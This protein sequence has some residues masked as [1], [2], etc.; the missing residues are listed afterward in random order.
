MSIILFCRMT[1]QSEAFGGEGE[2]SIP[3]EGVSLQNSVE[4]R[5]TEGSTT[6]PRYECNYSGCSRSYSTPSNLKT[7][8]RAHAGRL[9]HKCPH[10]DCDKA[11]LTSYQL[12]NHERS[13][14][15]ERPYKCNENGCDKRYTTQFRLMAHMRLHSGN[16]FKCNF[17]NCDKEFTTRSDLKKHK[18]IHTGEKPYECTMSGCGKKFT[19]SH[20]LKIHRGTHLQERQSY[21]CEDEGCSKAFKSKQHL[22]SHLS[23][24]HSQLSTVEVMEVEGG[25]SR[26]RN[27]LD[28]LGS[29]FSGP[30][31]N[32]LDGGDGTGSADLTTEPAD[33]ML[34]PSPFSSLLAGSDLV[35]LSLSQPLQHSQGGSVNLQPSHTVTVNTHKAGILEGSMQVDFPAESHPQGGLSLQGQPS[36]V[37]HLLN[38]FPLHSRESRDALPNSPVV[39]PQQ[40]SE[41]SL[42][43]VSHKAPMFLPAVSG[44][45]GSVKEA[46]SQ[47][48]HDDTRAIGPSVRAPSTGGLTSTTLK[49]GGSV[50]SEMLQTTYLA[51]QQLLS[52][53]MFK[54][55]LGKF[56]AELRCRC[57]GDV[58]C[59]TSQCKTEPDQLECCQQKG[60]CRHAECE[61]E[62]EVADAKSNW[63]GVDA[64]TPSVVAAAE[65][66]VQ[67][68][69]SSHPSN[70]PND[71]GATDSY[72]LSDQEFLHF[73]EDLLRTSEQPALGLSSPTHLMGAVQP[74]PTREV[75][76]QTNLGPKCSCRCGAG[77][78][79]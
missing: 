62:D 46:L 61:L 78:T 37:S 27:G 65:P 8:I 25:P 13:H 15:G 19:A 55:V 43:Y 4:G 67:S 35:P 24:T 31:L 34:V 70:N 73:V 10:S 36:S 20:H 44:Y 40:Q 58:F 33:I 54:Q 69:T 9:P 48:N 79:K 23:Q 53:G 64:G 39:Q 22:E 76:T 21:Q 57:V 77:G 38:T 75:G 7:H 16:T 52:N 60:C 72:N 71:A 42:S 17:A 32:R 26:V 30:D 45:S 29:P 2:Q 63:Q 18:R 68:A 51:M 50:S 66:S 59:G 5:S 49:D 47:S 56:A 11:F 6:G 1:D 14:T 28:L 3:V 12:K 41:F 74:K